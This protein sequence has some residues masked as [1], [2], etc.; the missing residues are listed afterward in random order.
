MKSPTDI[1]NRIDLKIKNRSDF[2]IEIFAEQY[3]VERVEIENWDG[4]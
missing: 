2:S 4:T 1:R 3:F